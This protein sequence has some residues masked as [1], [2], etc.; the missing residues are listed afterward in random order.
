MISIADL[1]KTGEQI[2]QNLLDHQASI[3]FI[4]G[5]MGIGPEVALA[6]KALPL[7]VGVLKFMQQESGKSLTE[8]FSDLMNHNIPGLPNSS[9]LAGPSQDPS[10]QGSG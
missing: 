9:A 3:N 5:M 6:E 10:A 2:V 1:E 4:A 8:V 7:L